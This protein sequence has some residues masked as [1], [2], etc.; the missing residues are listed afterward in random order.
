MDLQCSRSWDR[1]LP[2]K[3]IEIDLATEKY[4]ARNISFRIQHIYKSNAIDEGISELPGGI[5][6]IGGSSSRRAGVEL[7]QEAF[8]V[9][10]ALCAKSKIPYSQSSLCTCY[11]FVRVC[12]K[13]NRWDMLGSAAV[14]RWAI[15]PSTCILWASCSNSTTFWTQPV[16]ETLRSRSKKFNVMCDKAN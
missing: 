12:W 8:G 11:Q 4:L 15:T 16:D 9:N 5:V 7:A 6:I 10:V 13:L 14:Y 1:V 2:Q 3:R